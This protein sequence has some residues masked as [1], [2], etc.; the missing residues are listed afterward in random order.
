[1]A[2]ALARLSSH[3]LKV[4]YVSTT[5][6]KGARRKRAS[7]SLANEESI[8]KEAAAAASRYDVDVSTSL[9]A[10]AAPEE[11]ILQEIETS[12][13]DPAVLGVDRIQGE[14]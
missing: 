11:A 10:N 9:R 12:G 1:M 4:V 6:E 8:L 7:M 13:A 2:V 5:R 3:P 14:H